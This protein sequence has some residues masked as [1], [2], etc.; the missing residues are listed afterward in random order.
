MGVIT[1]YKQQLAVLRERFKRSL[2]QN[3]ATEIDFNTVDGFQ[4]REVD[5]LILSTVRAASGTGGIGFV[6]DVRRM[7]VALT[8]ARFSLWIVGNAAMLQSN[9]SWASLISNARSRGVIHTIS[10]PYMPFFSAA[11]PAI[12][13]SPGVKF[14]QGHEV[15]IVA[16]SAGTGSKMSILTSVD[17][18]E[19]RHKKPRSN[20]SESTRSGE[21]GAERKRSQFSDYPVGELDQLRADGP[22][23]IEESKRIAS[24]N[25]QG[26]KNFSGQHASCGKGR[27]DNKDGSLFQDP[28]ASGGQSLKG[29]VSNDAGGEQYGSR[30]ERSRVVHG[31]ISPRGHSSRFDHTQ[32]CE[33]G[34]HDDGRRAQLRE[35]QRLGDNRK[36]HIDRRQE[37]GSLHNREPHRNPATGDEGPLDTIRKYGSCGTSRDKSGGSHTQRGGEQIDVTLQQ[38]RTR[39]PQSD[40]H[41]SGRV[42]VNQ[43]AATSPHQGGKCVSTFDGASPMGPPAVTRGLQPV[44]RG[45]QVMGDAGRETSRSTRGDRIEDKIA[46]RKKQRAEAEAIMQAGLISSSG[47]ARSSSG[48]GGRVVMRCEAAEACLPN[49]PSCECGFGAIDVFLG[50]VKV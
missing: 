33:S 4:G 47:S 1:P 26:S 3:I 10:R 50:R 46:S 32:R 8:R 14:D 15:H 21:Y 22:S 48:V 13:S 27:A 11:S 43:P 16:A 7:N 44:K 38:P 9:P 34:R 28:G 35:S 31:N 24:A 23:P 39:A 29:A 41:V 37:V 19:P 40:R 12:G 30:K 49:T 36:R 6:A 5:I 45:S 17:G 18:R 20:R 2:G 42:A 25:D